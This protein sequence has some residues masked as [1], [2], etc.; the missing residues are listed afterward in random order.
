M[1]KVKKKFC[2]ERNRKMVSSEKFAY[3][4]TKTN[5]IKHYNSLHILNLEQI[6]L[7]SIENWLE[8][9]TTTEPPLGNLACPN[10]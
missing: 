9:T 8:P 6:L 10:P 2:L 4:D 5:Q 7:R 3:Q 1:G